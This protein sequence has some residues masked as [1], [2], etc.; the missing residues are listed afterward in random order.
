[1][2][3]IKRDEKYNKTGKRKI[4]MYIYDEN[5][6][7]KLNALNRSWIDLGGFGEKRD[8]QIESDLFVS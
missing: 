7:R 5:F 3:M 1:M 6:I 4:K 2:G 8:E